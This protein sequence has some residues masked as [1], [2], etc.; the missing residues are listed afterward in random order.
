MSFFDLA[1]DVNRHKHSFT[2]WPYRWPKYKSLATLAWKEY[3]FDVSQAHTVPENPGVYTFFIKPK[4]DTLDVSYLIYIG[5]TD[6]PLRERF[7]EYCRGLNKPEVRPKIY[8]WLKMYQGFVV[9][10][11][12]EVTAS[13]VT[14]KHIEDQLL[15][16]FIP[17]CNESFPAEVSKLV[18]A[19]S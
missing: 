14:P 16:A 17:P 4:V 5:K 6:R 15:M 10:R 1:S 13:A 11:C 2:L 18:R 9:F 3:V 19:F 8:S 12:A 7:V